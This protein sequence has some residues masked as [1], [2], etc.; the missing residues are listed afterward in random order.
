MQQVKQESVQGLTGN[1]ARG[2]EEGRIQKDS[3]NRRNQ[4]W[5]AKGFLA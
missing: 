1:R 3:G 4:T 2:G 5:G